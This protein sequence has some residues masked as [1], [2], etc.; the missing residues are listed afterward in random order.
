MAYATKRSHPDKLLSIYLND[1][2]AGATVGVE[3]ARRLRASNREEPAFGT[4]LAEIYA[5]IETDRE[6]LEEAMEH[7]GIAR[8][9]VKPAAAWAGEKLGRLKLNGQLTGYSPL[10]RLVELEL[11]LIGITGKLRMWKALERTRGELD[12]DFARLAE[13]AARQ[14]GRVEELHLLA[15]DMAFEPGPEKE[16]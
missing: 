9:R 13:R 1:H 16:S 10:S 4:P 15:A 3:L 2:L 5:E 12:V 8:G 6:A 14:R 7:L 11:L